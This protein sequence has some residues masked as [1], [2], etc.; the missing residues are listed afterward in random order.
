M[1]T[2]T[3]LVWTCVRFPSGLKG[4]DS[5]TNFTPTY[6]VREH[7]QDSYEIGVLLRSFWA[8]EAS[9]TLKDAQVLNF[10]DKLALEKVKKSVKYV[11]G[12]YQ[13]VIPWKH[14]EPELP[15][16]YEMRCVGC[17]T[18]KRGCGTTQRLERLTP[19]ASVSTLRK[20]TLER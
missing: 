3:P 9:G 5:Q 16:N 2:L 18:L 19:N 13:V 11:N 14:L 10:D 7:W 17:L 15:D 6:L 8:V 4:S 20:D 1:A 12:R